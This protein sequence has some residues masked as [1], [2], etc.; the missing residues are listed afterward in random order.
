[1]FSALNIANLLDQNSFTNA[2]CTKVRDALAYLSTHS[3]YILCLGEYAVIEIRH[4]RYFLAV[5]SELHFTS[6]A[7]QLHL[8]QPALSQNIRQLEEDLGVA[9]LERS[10]R[11]VALTDAG[12]VFKHEAQAILDHLNRAALAVSR[13]T[14][15]TSGRLLLGFTGHAFF[16]GFAEPVEAFRAKY[17]DVE[18]VAEEFVPDELVLKLKT[19]ELDLICTD[20]E[21]VDTDLVSLPLRRLPLMCAVSK[22]HRFAAMDRVELDALRTETLI[23]PGKFEQHNYYDATLRRCSMVGFEPRIGA[24]CKTFLGGLGLVRAGFGVMLCYSFP[25]GTPLEGVEF[26]AVG[27]S[28]F[29]FCLQLLWRREF[30]VRASVSNF[31]R[32]AQA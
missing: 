17:P 15:G 10:S 28:G 24:Y 4:L 23:F 13:A 8:A 26:R 14:E 2:P 3:L 30:P 21:V 16:S 6:A 9:L 31:V 25:V 11:N 29:D 32:I 18:L 1:M 22:T 19:G 12:V 7:K 20:A 27:E 5:A